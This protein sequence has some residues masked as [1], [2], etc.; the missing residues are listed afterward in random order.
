MVQ[1]TL[2]RL[3]CGTKCGSCWVRTPECL[4]LPTIY[5]GVSLV[6]KGSVRWWIT[7]LH[8]HRPSGAPSRPQVLSFSRLDTD[9]LDIFFHVLFSRS[10]PTHNFPLPRLPTGCGTLIC[11]QFFDEISCRRHE[12]SSR[13]RRWGSGGRCLQVH[14]PSGRRAGSWSIAIE[15]KLSMI[16]LIYDSVIDNPLL[17]LICYLHVG[18]PPL[19][20]SPKDHILMDK[21]NERKWRALVIYVNGE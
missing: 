21:K 19:K 13:T 5:A 17:P 2:P 11:H 9:I 18:C 12:D 1:G 7:W 4:E 20:I 3:P 8:S 16:F 6:M 10:L 15:S 14:R